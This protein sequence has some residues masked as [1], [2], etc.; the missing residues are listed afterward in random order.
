VVTISKPNHDPLLSELRALEVELSKRVEEAKNKAVESINQAELN[1]LREKEDLLSL[2]DELQKQIFDEAIQEGQ[3]EINHLLSEFNDQC[4][5]F[6][7]IIKNQESAWIQ[8]L[9]DWLFLER[10]QEDQ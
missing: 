8:V 5:L 4:V 7:Q 2:K 1:I 3:A 10:Q 9:L 6:E